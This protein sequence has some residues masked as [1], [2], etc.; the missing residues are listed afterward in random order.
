MKT[1][2]PYFTFKS[3]SEAVDD[4]A[5]MHPKRHVYRADGAGRGVGRRFHECDLLR[6]DCLQDGPPA[7]RARPPLKLAGHRG[8]PRH[9]ID[10]RPRCSQ[11][12]AVAPC[13][14][15]V[16]MWLISRSHRDH[17]PSVSCTL[18]SS[19]SPCSVPLTRCSSLSSR[20]S[21]TSPSSPRSPRN[22]AWPR[23]TTH[24]DTRREPC[25]P[26]SAS[27]VAR[28]LFFVARSDPA[29][30]RAL[31]SLSRRVASLASQVP[32]P[33]HVHERDQRVRRRCLRPLPHRAQDAD[34]ERAAVRQPPA[35]GPGQRRERLQVQVQV[36]HGPLS[37]PFLSYPVACAWHPVCT[38]M[39][40][41]REGGPPSR[42]DRTDSRPRFPPPFSLS[43]DRVFLL[44]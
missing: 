5:R 7:T 25:L 2:L 6:R 40:Q 14:K 10:A 18:S 34:A 30:P 38:S 31:S 35:R 23:R 43:E 8:A 19:S 17:R 15:P 42:T 39:V 29:A 9:A 21:T 41:P 36:R 22:T 32:E 16:L 13:P 28:T 24:P 11:C 1:D 3:R 26:S 20:S 33:P 44:F 4:A 37:F 27:R 12:H